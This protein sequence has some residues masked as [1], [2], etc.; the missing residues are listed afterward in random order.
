MIMKN[1]LWVLAIGLIILYGAQAQ[2][3]S[4]EKKPLGELNW[5]DNDAIGVIPP[6]LLRDNSTSLI[7]DGTYTQTDYTQVSNLTIKE[8]LKGDSLTGPIVALRSSKTNKYVHASDET[9]ALLAESTSTT[10]YDKF[11]FIKAD[12]K[13][14]L[15]NVATKGY[16]ANTR[17]IWLTDELWR[18]R[19]CDELYEGCL[20]TMEYNR[21]GGW[22]FRARNGKY[23]CADNDYERIRATSY[24]KGPSETFIL[25][26]VGSNLQDQINAVSS[27]GTVYLQE[28]VYRGSA[29]IDKPVNIIG[30]TSGTFLD[31]GGK[32]SVLTIGKSNPNVDVGLYQIAIRGGSSEYGGGINNFGRLTL[33]TIL[34]TGNT[35]SNSGGGIFNHGSTVCTTAVI[36]N[37]SANLGAGIFNDVGSKLV[38][39]IVDITS[40]TAGKRGGGVLNKGNMVFEGGTIWANIP[41]EVQDD[42]ANAIVGLRP[43]GTYGDGFLKMN[44][45][46]NNS[47]IVRGNN[48]DEMAFATA[49]ATVCPQ[50]AGN[51]SALTADPCCQMVSG[52]CTKFGNCP[53]NCPQ[54]KDTN[55]RW[56]DAPVYQCMSW[57]HICHNGNYKL[58]DDPDP[59]HKDYKGRCK[60]LKCT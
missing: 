28:G 43:A 34:I 40:N 20:F 16:I 22:S 49:N 23:M 60:I 38:L 32:G 44:T 48:T 51:L 24:D 30:S 25:E 11:Y 52:S 27:G 9:V 21:S 15:K 2:S 19:E 8:F 31:G 36:S 37:N 5:S 14:A 56:T 54:C 26:V 17:F 46:F 3:E 39:D 53:S 58:V 4:L 55:R 10:D 45:G 18:L 6:T 13:V 59:S 35:A 41:D 29:V 1:K 50:S 57:L 42:T 33:E 7:N 47:G 12:G